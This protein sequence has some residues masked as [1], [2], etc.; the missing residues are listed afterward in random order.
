VN[1]KKEVEEKP[2]AKIKAK[3]SEVSVYTSSY[4]KLRIKVNSISY[5][6][7]NGELKTSDPDVI[8]HCES[9]AHIHK[10]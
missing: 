5:Q 1:K 7:R 9:S 8:K 10:K 3:V 2:K 6:F 4:T